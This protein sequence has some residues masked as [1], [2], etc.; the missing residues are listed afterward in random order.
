M[1]WAKRWTGFSRIRKR[2]AKL[3]LV[4]VTL[5]EEANIEDCLRSAD[6]A[7]EIVVVD[8]RSSDR[9]VELARKFTDKVFVADFEGYGRIKGEAVNKASGEWIFS[10]DADERVSPELAREIQEVIDRDD[11]CAGYLVRRKT[12]FL[13]RWMTHGGWHP[14]YVLRL[15]RKDAGG[16]DNALV[17]ES[18]RVRG[19]VKRLESDLVHYSDRDLAHYLWKLDRFTSLSAQSLFDEGRK[20]GVRDLLLRPPFL[21]VK[22][23]V[24]K[25]GFLDGMHGLVLALLSSFHV[26]LK[27]VKLWEKRRTEKSK[28]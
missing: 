23:Y 13:G 12:Y 1:I 26:L 3:S 21:F 15:F 5:N 6:F 28:A 10:L 17:H 19:R 22:M 4:V 27:Y 24:F 2:M 20:A 16:F 8:S 18:V 7:D 9:T 25:R 14:D 11:G